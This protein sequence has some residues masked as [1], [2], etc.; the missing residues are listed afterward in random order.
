MSPIL[1]THESKTEKKTNFRDPK[2]RIRQ[3]GNQVTGSHFLGP[4]KPQCERFALRAWGTQISGLEASISG[5]GSP[6][7]RGRPTHFW[8]SDQVVFLKNWSRCTPYLSNSYVPGANLLL[9]ETSILDIR[10]SFWGMIPFIVCTG[11]AHFSSPA[12][13][14]RWISVCQH[15]HACLP[16]AGFHRNYGPWR[17]LQG[18]SN[19]TPGHV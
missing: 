15:P 5:L 17:P 2:I 6:S 1:C 4:R 19:A 3:P 14:W 13:I 8:G 7:F 11:G 16:P 18:A 10:A 12:H 9:W